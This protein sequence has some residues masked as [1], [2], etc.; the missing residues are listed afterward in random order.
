[1][2]H[3]GN[4]SPTVTKPSLT[5]LLTNPALSPTPISQTPADLASARSTSQ[6]LPP[7]F[8]GLDLLLLHQPPPSLSLMSPSF[9]SFGLPLA[10]PCGPIE[11]VLKKGRPRYVFWSAGEGFWEREPF[12][13]SGSAGKEERWTR[14]VKLSSL[15]EQSDGKK[16]RVSPGEIDVWHRH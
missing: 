5:Q 4:Y 15:G 1:M 12:G 7:A 11:E 16:A 13:W 14:S 10:E 6:A 3:Q 2:H 8:Q 9:T